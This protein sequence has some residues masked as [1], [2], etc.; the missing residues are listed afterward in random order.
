[1]SVE[2]LAPQRSLN[3]ASPEFSI[4]ERPKSNDRSPSLL[5]FWIDFQKSKCMAPRRWYCWS[6]LLINEILLETKRDYRGS[7]VL[8]HE[9][10][11]KLESLAET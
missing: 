3:V 9:C 8:I 6:E 7:G 5:P 2:R 4:S 1:M 11:S 10:D